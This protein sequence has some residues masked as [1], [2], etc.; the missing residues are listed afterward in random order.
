MS[1]ILETALELHQ[2]GCSVIPTLPGKKP[3]FA[4]KK[5]QETPASEAEIRAWYTA[6][7]DWGLA[8]ICGEI[9]GNLTM[10][11]LEGRAA[12]RYAELKALFEDHGQGELWETINRGWFEQSPSG[13]LHWFIRGTETP[14]GNQKLAVGTNK[15]V[16]A[17]TRG[18]GGYVIVAPTP[19][20][21]HPSGQPWARITGGPNTAPILNPA[22][23]ETVLD[24]FRL[25]DE[26]GA[27]SEPQLPTHTPTPQA[28]Q[29]P[30][31]RPGD[32]YNQEA[33]WDQILIGWHKNR[34]TD[35]TTYWT[36][37][38]KNPA[39]GDSA[40]TGH[41]TDGVDRLY[42]FST[43]TEFPTEEPISKFRAYS[44]LNHGGD[45]QTAARTLGAGGWGTPLPQIEWDLKQEH[46]KP[47]LQ[48]IQGN[49]ETVT[50]GS[51]ALKTDLQPAGAFTHDLTEA[52]AGKHLANTYADQIRYVANSDRWLAWN[53]H[54]W[55]QTGRA[56][57]P[58]KQRAI[59]TF[60]AME[61]SSKE[62]AAF[63]KQLLKNAGLN[64]ALT[65]A[66][67]DPRITIDQ[68]LLD[69]HP[70]ELNTP[71]GIIN[72]HTGKLLP[73]DPAKL[74]TRSAL[75]APE[76]SPTPMWDQFLT[77]T[78]EGHPGIVDYVQ[79][80][81]G[82]SATGYIKSQILP[83]L[84]GAGANGKSVV[85]EVIQRL[86]GDYAEPA[87]ANFL[88]VTGIQHPTEIARLQ[89]ARMVV[90]SEVSEGS[91]FDE[92]KVKQLTGGDTLTGRY[93]HGDFFTFQ[94]THKLWLL[95]NHLPKVSAGGYS[96][97]RRLRQ[98]PFTNIVPEDKR[99][100]DLTAQLLEAEGAGILQWVIEGAVKYLAG[101][102]VEPDEVRV[103][104]QAYEDSE[105][106]LKQFVDDRLHVGGGEFARVPYR[107]MRSA[108]ADWCRLEGQKP[109]T[110]NA[111][112]R[113]I[114]TRFN[115]GIGRNHGARL[116]TN[117]MLL[118]DADEPEE[119]QE[120]AFSSLG[121]G[122]QW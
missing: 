78:F 74:H 4:W 56:N 29:T 87:P 122:S 86:L 60:T 2:F 16:L 121:G 77:D 55:E 98:I 68:K 23:V 62:A 5:H 57:A 64:S 13:G 45:D 99:N 112:T 9:S 22:E 40:T 100:P 49:N 30:G 31:Q 34:V 95:G 103:A 35:G 94:P 50:D 61:A 8:V 93:M 38:G 105:D 51:S 3:A 118:A 97:W 63:R 27:P 106:H 42:V 14:A 54:A 65:L 39:E 25:L 91:K 70:G 88:M 6:H 85:A 114:Q 26:T 41:S 115:I 116:Y 108:Y 104:T 84:Y 7:P 10:I 89:G 21:H 67:T 58:I 96:F 71:G 66:A 90:A 24:L 47:A 119:D 83:F 17:E 32:Q 113:E 15:L 81:A 72:L 46:A 48:I 59:N 73:S 107:E 110:A 37:P 33:S 43:S 44:I 20:S 80:L 111:F 12:H 11:E 109:A 79:Q 82:Y 102:L 53:G 120:N 75:C 52:W 1:S 101:G 117:C 92:S 28:S 69:A 36:R 19:V 76:A 18:N